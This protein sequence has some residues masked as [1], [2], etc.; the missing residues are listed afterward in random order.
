MLDFGLNQAT[1]AKPPLVEFLEV[2]NRLG[3]VGV[4]L[5]NDLGRPLFDGLSADAVRKMLEDQGL[6]LLGLSQIYPFN[7]WSDDIE[8]D[9]RHL[10]DLA[11]L[12]GAETISLVPYNPSTHVEEH[13]LVLALESC[14]PLLEAAGVVALVEPLGF[15]HATLRTKAELVAA[16]ETLGAQQHIRLV[17]DTFHHRLANEQEIFPDQTG[18]VHISGVSIADIAVAHM[19]DE[20]RVLINQDDRLGNLDQIMQLR[21]AGY[22]G[23]Y[24]FECFS[25]IIQQRRSVE[26]DIKASMNFISSHVQGIAA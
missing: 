17:H 11:V 24:S 10:L 6:R 7:R 12:T 26:Q 13:S 23:A 22:V 25:P 2:A 8:T 5:R 19:K 1:M 9:M 4:E 15:A 14:L 20:H 18:I 21:A 16:V 3:M